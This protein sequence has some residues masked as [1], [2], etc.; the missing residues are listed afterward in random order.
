MFFYTDTQPTS[1]IFYLQGNDAKCLLLNETQFENLVESS[2]QI[3][4]G[5]LERKSLNVINALI[6]TIFKENRKFSL[7]QLIL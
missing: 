2:K 1:L 5:S 3:F 4:T 6:I 7:N